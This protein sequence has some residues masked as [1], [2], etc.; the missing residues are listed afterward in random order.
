MK[1][2]MFIHNHAW[3]LI[4]YNFSIAVTKFANKENLPFYSLYLRCIGPSKWCTYTRTYLSIT[5]VRLASYY[6]D[7]SG[8]R[9]LGWILSISCTTSARCSPSI[10]L[11]FFFYSPI[12]RAYVGKLL[13]SSRL[14]HPWHWP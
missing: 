2:A 8:M 7:Y 9:H 5:V 4:M 1:F 6:N 3:G 11:F 14:P 13:V 10:S 12:A